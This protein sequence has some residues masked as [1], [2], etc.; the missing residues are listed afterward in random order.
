[1][2]YQKYSSVSYRNTIHLSLNNSNDVKK[3]WVLEALKIAD[4]RSKVGDKIF[5]SGFSSFFWI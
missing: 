5:S 4:W 1:M 2:C 3:V